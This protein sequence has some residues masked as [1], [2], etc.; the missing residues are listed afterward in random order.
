MLE[1][2]TLILDNKIFTKLQN[3]YIV[4]FDTC[5]YS[6]VVSSPAALL[7]NDIINNIYKVPGKHIFYAVKRNEKALSPYAF[8]DSSYGTGLIRMFF[9]TFEGNK[10]QI[11]TNNEW[12]NKVIDMVKSYEQSFHLNMVYIDLK[13]VL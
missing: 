12:N 10:N 1:D 9:L 6:P 4:F 2:T 3:N 8:I 13:K 11:D 7:K 5:N